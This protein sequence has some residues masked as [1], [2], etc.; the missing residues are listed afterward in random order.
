[1]DRGE[2]ERKRIIHCKNVF[3]P[4]AIINLG[5]VFPENLHHR[6][7]NNNNEFLSTY[8]GSGTMTTTLHELSHLIL[9]G[10]K[11]KF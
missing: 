3:S 10:I 8:C 11:L 6:S 1:M 2:G 9:K 5:L 7:E 4:N